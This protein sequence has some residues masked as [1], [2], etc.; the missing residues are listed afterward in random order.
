DIVYATL[1][2]NLLALLCFR[3][4]ERT[5]RVVDVVD[6]WPDV[7]P[8]PRSVKWLLAPLFAVWRRSFTAAIASADI[9]IAVS[10]RF[11]H[12]SLPAFRGAPDAARRLYIGHPPL[13]RSTCTHADGLTIAYVG[14]IGHL[15][16][17]ETLLD[18]MTQCE[19][20]PKLLLVGDG[21]RRASLLEALTRRGIS[22]E[23]FGIVYD[24]TTLAGILCRADLGFNGYRNTS[25]A[26]SYKA[27]TYLASGLPL[28]NSMS[29]DLHDLVAKHEF[30][31]ND[32]AEDAGA[33]VE[34]LRA[35]TP[36]TLK[37][38]RANAERFFCECLDQRR[39]KEELESWLRSHLRAVRP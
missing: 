10:D 17:L 20:I 25:A 11:L 6:I 12:E 37:R 26:F 27:N 32:R 19:V 3:G 18:A 28:L 36:A 5:L 35:A 34:C 31:F 30:G 7:L 14:N 4:G 13:P 1:P 16:D 33:L 21:D 9:L 23:Y 15:C 39:L 24:D 8:F 2:F 38:L 22:H 29:G